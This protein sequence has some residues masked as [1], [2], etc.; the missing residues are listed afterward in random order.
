MLSGAID[1]KEIV[2]NLDHPLKG[3]G[4]KLTMTYEVKP[5]PV[6][7]S[8]DADHPNKNEPTNKNPMRGGMLLLIF[9]NQEYFKST[10]TTHELLYQSGN[11][12]RPSSDE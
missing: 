6:H 12:R 1:S 5:T 3:G 11:F 9:I 10:R 7:Y 4:N 2:Q 8:N